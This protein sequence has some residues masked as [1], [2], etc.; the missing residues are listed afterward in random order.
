MYRQRAPACAGAIAAILLSSCGAAADIA[1]RADR[2]ATVSLAVEVPAAVEAR[3]RQFASSAGT[4][5][6][7]SGVPLFDAAAVSSSVAARGVSVR[8]SSSPDPRS[9]RGTFVVADVRRLLG[10]DRDLAAVMEYARSPGRASV[11]L[12]VDRGNARAV[13][14]LFPGLDAELLESLQPPALYDNPVSAAEYRSMLAGLLG[15]A[16]AA[17]IDGARIVLSAS[18][19]GEIVESSPGVIVDASRKSASLSIPAIEAMVLERPVDFHIT[20]KE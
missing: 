20:W 9:Y 10:A 15:K 14:A 16:A 1:F 6:A 19:P 7:G 4:G 8:S 13:V 5:A 11:R 3:I 12:R 2:S 18:F 17:G